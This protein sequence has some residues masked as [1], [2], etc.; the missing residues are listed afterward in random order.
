MAD[1]SA[2]NSSDNIR[3]FI[4]KDTRGF[5]K[6]TILGKENGKIL[7]DIS[8]DAYYILDY[9][10]VKVEYDPFTTYLTRCPCC[11]SKYS[12]KNAGTNKTG[13]SAARLKAKRNIQREVY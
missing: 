13:N 4:S 10:K 8:G 9:D 7:I 5:I 2:I 6:G 12:K 1:F 3:L 11:Q